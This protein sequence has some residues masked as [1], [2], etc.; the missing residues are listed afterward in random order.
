M[1]K[2]IVISV[3]IAVSSLALSAC[4]SMMGSSD[5]SMMDGDNHMSSTSSKYDA[6][7][8]MFA[9]MM[10]PH[11]AQALVMSDIA[12]MKSKS[13]EIL[14]LA[15]EIKAAQKP[16]MTKMQSWLDTAPGYNSGH[17]DHG[18]MQG[19]L[20]GEELDELNSLTGTEFDNA[21]LRA[22]INHHQGALVMTQMISASSDTEV[23]ALGEEI[24]KA[25]TAEIELMKT[26][27]K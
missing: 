25:Q 22:M 12:I 18:N 21:F 13:Q 10:I 19:M 26:M 6:D 17:M 23:K 14:Q 1:K 2:E 4:S 5:H 9:S 8:L 7:A 24:I 11:H 15:A 16:E 3:L 20:T 27:I